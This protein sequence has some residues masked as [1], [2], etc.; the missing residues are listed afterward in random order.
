MYRKKIYRN[1][2][3]DNELTSYCIVE[4]ETDLLVST[5]FDLRSKARALI[6]ECRRYIEYYIH[7]HPLF[8]TAL[9]PLE[10][11]DSAPDIIKKMLNAGIVAG[12]GPM[13]AVAGSVAEYA[14]CGLL[15]YSD[16][17]IVENGGDIFLKTEKHATIAIFSGK[18]PLNMR[19]GI[20]VDCSK[21]PLS[22]CTSSGTI[23]H[24]LS[25]GKADAV[26]VISKS[27]AIADAAA[28]SVANR[29]KTTKDI[30]NALLFGEGIKGV[31]GIVIVKDD[32]I[33]FWGDIKVV[34][35]LSKKG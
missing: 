22:I 27:G 15:A 5:S 2:V 18:S 14:G 11:D 6:L 29:V 30:H 13:A 4:K 23:G 24:S 1:L 25:Y 35:V 7:C 26:C 3:C 9:H 12:V 17:V 21:Q 33:G 31:L 32:E 16:Y 34:P 20:S 8:K 19:I 10:M 28:T